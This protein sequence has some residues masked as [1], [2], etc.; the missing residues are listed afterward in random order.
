MNRRLVFGDVIRVDPKNALVPQPDN[1]RWMIV[2]F[3]DRNKWTV[4]F[5]GPSAALGTTTT[6]VTFGHW[7]A[8]TGFTLVEP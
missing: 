4:L 2:S 5:I 6:L 7:P 1:R 8:L 3:D